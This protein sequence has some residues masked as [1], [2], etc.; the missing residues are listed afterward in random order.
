[1]N[2]LTESEARRFISDGF[3]NEI[4]EFT[5][6]DD[7][8]ALVLAKC[9]KN[10]RLDGLLVLS[11]ISAKMLAKHKGEPKEI[12]FGGLNCLSASIALEL[13][14]YTGTLFFPSLKDLNE[15]TA[16]ALAKHKGPK[17]SI[18]GI[19]RLRPEI[20]QALSKY[21]GDIELSGITE[22]CESEVLALG[23]YSGNLSLDGLKTVDET[24]AVALSNRRGGLSLAG[25]SILNEKS[26]LAF[27]E[28]LGRL[29]MP[30]L[31]EVSE[32]VVSMFDR[33]KG[34]VIV[35][36]ATLIKINNLRKFP[37]DFE[38]I[39]P[40]VAL[41]LIAK[42][43]ANQISIIVRDDLNLDLIYKRLCKGKL[44]SHKNLA[45]DAIKINVP[46]WF[47]KRWSQ[48]PEFWENVEAGVWPEDEYTPTHELRICIDDSKLNTLLN[49]VVIANVT[50]E[51]SWL[52]PIY[53]GFGGWNNCPQAFEHSAVLR[54]W[55]KKYGAK[56]VSMDTSTIEVMVDCPVV[57]QED[58]LSLARDQ[59]VYCPDI[60]RQGYGTVESLACSLIG[61]SVWSFWWD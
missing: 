59:Y 3:G 43:I 6:L 37:F 45:A 40:R 1:M 19:S 29:K 17:L 22:L 48:D 49:E 52:L 34:D 32:E 35:C 54:Y 26:A 36:P 16:V 23:K 31:T 56:L 9:K 41:E 20:A 57:S 42:P 33:H 53:L 58:A 7:S 27:G 21:K 50:C 55:N 30:C 18:N 38:R 2:N 10:L 28:H 13:S 46:K 24:V 4:L 8:A 39:L 60:V 14:K 44:E 51:E 5:S 61:S 47:R 15:E 12:S 11:E 25:V